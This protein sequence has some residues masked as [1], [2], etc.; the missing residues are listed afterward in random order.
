GFPGADVQEAA[1]KLRDFE[2]ALFPDLPWDGDE[3]MATA[4]MS[5]ELLDAESEHVEVVKQKKRDAVSPETSARIAQWAE[6][7]GEPV[8]PTPESSLEFLARQ[9]R[10]LES[11]LKLRLT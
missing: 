2:R 6:R 5:V 4:R 11:M 10:F 8:P 3:E 1:R 9:L 7:S